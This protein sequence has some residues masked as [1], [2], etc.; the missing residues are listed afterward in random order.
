M[1]N[2]FWMSF[3]LTMFGLIMIVFLVATINFYQLEENSLLKSVHYTPNETTNSST[4][5]EKNTTSNN[6][7]TENNT[8]SNVANNLSENTSTTNVS[9]N[10][11]E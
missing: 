5:S 6:T 9:D 3:I 7:S 10:S 1:K 11:V 2:K 8:T 4:S